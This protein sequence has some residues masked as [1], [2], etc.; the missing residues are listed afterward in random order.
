MMN[1]VSIAWKDI[2]IVLR[3]KGQ[4]IMLFLLPMVFVVV[5]SAV[6]EL[7]DEEEKTINLPVVNQDDA[8]DSARNL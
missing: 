2:Q 3:E 4:L 7:Q 1:I 5:F 6:F 8:G